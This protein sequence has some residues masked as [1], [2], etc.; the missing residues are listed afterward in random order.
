VPIT[1][2]LLRVQHFHAAHGSC[3]MEAPATTATSTSNVDERDWASLPSDVLKYIFYVA[4]TWQAPGSCL[5]APVC[6]A[7]R[8]AAAGCS[9]I[10][11]LYL[12]GYPAADESF[13]AWLEHN[14][15]QLG[16]L[17]ISSRDSYSAANGPLRALAEAAA[18]AAAAGRPLRL[19]TLRV[20]GNGPDMEVTGLLLVGLPELACLQLQHG[21]IAGDIGYSEAA[22]RKHL[23]PLKQARQLEEFHSYGPTRGTRCTRA[24][25]RR[26]PASLKRLS[27]SQCSGVP[28]HV[29]KLTHL[30]SVTSLQLGGWT[31]VQGFSRQLPPSIQQVFVD[32]HVYLALLQDMPGV[33]TGYN[34]CVPRRQ[35][36]DQLQLLGSHTSL[37]SLS[38]M[39]ESLERPEVYDAL[40]KLRSLVAVAVD[41]GF[42]D[43]GNRVLR[44]LQPAVSA[45][46]SFQGL[47]SLVLH[48]PRP[49]PQPPQLAALTQLTRLRVSS[50]TMTAAMSRSGSRSWSS[51]V[52]GRSR[53]A[54]CPGCG[55]CLFQLCC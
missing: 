32:R 19:H 29:P 53:W 49:L 35:G 23:A 11:L 43:L 14:S 1:L 12:A 54:A 21:C 18:A 7:W 33:L 55:G 45:I 37:R 25:A 38:C 24:I 9:G 44:N 36:G 28:Q 34:D 42:S 27:W 5:A 3:S 20:L 52:A 26:L 31:G 47:R 17:I 4:S 41:S 22:V 15:P 6:Q 46:A 40:R 13:R 16:S 30:T 48:V 2:S 8:T 10:R 51:G 39:A 50:W